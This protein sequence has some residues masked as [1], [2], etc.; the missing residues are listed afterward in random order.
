MFGK[1]L[2]KVL[3]DIIGLALVLFY[4]SCLNVLIGEEFLA[5]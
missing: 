3:I 4:A 2:N 1:D 5:N